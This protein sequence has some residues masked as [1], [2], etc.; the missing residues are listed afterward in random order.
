MIGTK[1]RPVSLDIRARRG[2]LAPP[3]LLLAHRPSRHLAEGAAAGPAF[4]QGFAVVRL[5]CRK[6]APPS[7]ARCF[8]FAPPPPRYRRLGSGER[9]EGDNFCVASE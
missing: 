1:P 9:G 3:R 7:N 6:L 4:C 5:F 2:L 8:N